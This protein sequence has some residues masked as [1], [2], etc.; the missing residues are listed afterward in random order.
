MYVHYNMNYV[1]KSKDDNLG[2]HD[3]STTFQILR[4]SL[5]WS[6]TRHHDSLISQNSSTLQSICCLTKQFKTKIICNILF[7]HQSKLESIEERAS[8]EDYLHAENFMGIMYC[9]N[10]AFINTITRFISGRY[11]EKFHFVDEKSL[12][13]PDFLRLL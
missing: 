13:S 6:I 2:H 4:L 3:F 8:S 1:I 10:F 12:Y 5:S 9:I 11:R 7:S